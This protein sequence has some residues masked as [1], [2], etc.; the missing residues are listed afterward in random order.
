MLHAIPRLHAPSLSQFRKA[1]LSKS[2]PAVVSGALGSWPAL[3][4]GD[5]FDDNLVRVC[6]DRPLLSECDGNTGIVQFDRTY[7][8]TSWA[9]LADV[10]KLNLTTVRDLLH[11]FRHD[12][13]VEVQRGAAVADAVAPETQRARASSLYLWDKSIDVLCPR[14]LDQLRVP[15]YFPVDYT[16]QC[17]TAW[18]RMHRHLCSDNSRTGAAGHPA[19]FIGPA[20]TGSGLHAD[21]EA[22]RFWMVVLKGQKRFRLIAPADAL[23]HL[24]PTDVVAAGG[25]AADYPGTFNVDIFATPEIADDAG[26]CGSVGVVANGPRRG[27][28][29]SPT[30]K[31][32]EANVSAG[33]LI[34]IPQKWA[35]QVQN[36]ED[37]VA[38]SMNFVDEWSW[39]GHLRYLQLQHAVGKKHEINA[40]LSSYLYDHQN[41]SFPR[42][43]VS[44][45]DRAP[46]DGGAGVLQS[47]DDVTWDQFFARN[48]P[49][50]HP[51]WD[52]DA[53]AAA[54]AK[55]ARFREQT[56]GAMTVSVKAL[57]T[58]HGA[59][60][61]RYRAERLAQLRATHPAERVVSKDEL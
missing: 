15:R 45:F 20:G 37:T 50:Q 36:V 30:L 14:L 9:A 23:A 6:G 1:H 18:A 53:Y 44:D 25:G 13:T 11:A 3:Q 5:A 8:G 21:S 22:S 35:H 52:R 40:R 49:E 12:S 7:V 27:A 31:V 61:R 2:T 29:L 26:A 47:D 19:I 34:F 16:Q 32:W 24:H 51:Q 54:V 60:G 17:A 48:Q 59:K 55:W 56:H 58:T 41:G 33:D 38:I 42:L 43:A 46:A 39:K 28:C 57:L 4:W 10:E